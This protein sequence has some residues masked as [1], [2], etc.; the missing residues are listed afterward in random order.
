MLTTRTTKNV[1]L[2]DKVVILAHD[3]HLAYVG[4]P[5]DALAD[6]D[7]AGF[8]EVYDRLEEAAPE[9]WS[10]WYRTTQAHHDVATSLASVQGAGGEGSPEHALVV[11]RRGGFRQ[12]MHRLRVL[13]ARNFLLHVGKAQ[14]IMPL[15]MQPVVISLLIMAL[16]PS[17]IWE[18]STDNPSAALQMIFTF[19][20]VM[21]LF[22]LLFGAQETVKERSIFRRERGVG[23]RVLPYLL[24]KTTF[25]APLIVLTAVGM[26]ALWATGR[27]PDGGLDVYL[28]LVLTMIL[29]GWAGLAM[30]LLISSVVSNSQQATDLL[31]PW[32]APQVLF[33]GALFTVPSMNFVGRALSHITAV[34]WSFEAA[35]HVTDIKAFFAATN[36]EIG[37]ALLIQYDASFNTRPLVYW[38]IL[39]VFV[40]VPL[41]ASVKVLELKARPT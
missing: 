39:A 6:L 13:S 21:F 15:V 26:N 30:A 36:S 38:V 34:R 4:P 22:G 33:A 11:R 29:T 37:E 24:S 23:V 10:A 40:L 28:P 12:F 17:G 35:S 16:F 14:N 18:D 2:C 7:V 5:A 32:I 41:V 31:T 8:D 20:F 27:L 9:E 1:S 25:L 3:G 19:A